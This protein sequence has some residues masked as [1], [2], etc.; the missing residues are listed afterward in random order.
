LNSQPADAQAAASD[1]GR[2]DAPGSLGKEQET[3]SMPMGGQANNDNSTNDAYST[4]TP[5]P[6]Q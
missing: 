1:Q 5:P 2:E 4:P 3:Q 6:K